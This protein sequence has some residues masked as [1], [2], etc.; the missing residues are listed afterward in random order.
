[1]ARIILP[2]TP[3][4][5]IPVTCPPLLRNWDSGLLRA[6]EFGVELEGFVPLDRISSEDLRGQSKQRQYEALA[7]AMQQG[8]DVVDRGGKLKMTRQSKPIL[9]WHRFFFGSRRL[10]YRE[11]LLT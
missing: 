4:F 5:T 8:T 11:T 2:N 6:V 3:A 7:A 10:F 9:S 1:M